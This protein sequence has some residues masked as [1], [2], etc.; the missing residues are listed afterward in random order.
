MLFT[1]RVH[2]YRGDCKCS[3]LKRQCSV[4]IEEATMLDA[5]ASLIREPHLLDADLDESMPIN[6]IWCLDVIWILAKCCAR[7]YM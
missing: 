2:A 7:V 1:R 3:T 5:K 4:V 6:R